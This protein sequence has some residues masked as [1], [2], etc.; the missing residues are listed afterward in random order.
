MH[1]CPNCGGS[2]AD[3]ARFCASCGS[4]L[5]SAPPVCARC[6]TELPAGARFCPSCG[7]PVEDR[8]SPTAERKV[9]TILFADV[10]GST[11]LGERLD[12]EQLRTVL[13]TYFAAMREEIEAEGGTVEKFIGDAVM[14]AFGVPTAHEDDVARALRAAL[15]ML[16]RLASVNE[17]LRADHGVELEIR[18]GVNTGDVLAT[19]EARAGE[20]MVTGDAVNVAARLETA[21]RPGQ[22][23]AA[24]RTVR[25][26]RGFRVEDVGALDLKGKTEPIR[27][28]RV[29]DETVVFPDRGVSGLRAPLVGRDD[30]ID[31]LTS[32]F[33]RV[34]REG[35]PHLVTLYGDAGV[36][37]SRLTREFVESIA[38][39][40]T[41]VRGRCLPYG[42][43]VTFWP[44]A[45][46]LKAQA[47][48]LDT[49]PTEVALE[50]IRKAGRDLL[51]P[52]LTP[53]PAKTTAALAF[54]VGVEDPAFAFGEMDPKDVRAE[55][56]EAWRSF[57][58]A[59][60]VSGPVIALV[61]DI[62]WADPELLALLEDLADRSV[63]P[64]LVLCP[65]RPEL[66]ARHPTWGGGRRNHTAITLDPLSP[67]ESDRLVAY[68]LA[69]DDLPPTVRARILERAEG[70]PFF[71]EEILR[72]L[73]D[74]GLLVHE[75]HRW[76][77]ASG[78]G[79]A[80]IPDTVQGV[81][82]ARIDLLE[83]DDKRVLQAAAVVGRVFWPGSL[84]DLAGAADVAAT[85][86]RLE[87]REL[88]LS[89]LGSSIGGERE[90]L[91]KHIL[92]RDVAYETL[93]KR[94][95]AQAH[96]SVARWIERTAGERAREFV[97][98]LAY[99]YATAVAAR[100][101][102]DE[103]LRRRAVEYLL[104]ASNEA[105]SR[106]VL[107]KA[108][109]L[110]QDALSLTASDAERVRALETLA[111]VFFAA[112]QGDLGWRYFGEAAHLQARLA[113]DTSDPKVAYLCA[114]AAEFPTRWPGS[115]RTLADPAAVEAILDLGA[116]H[117][118]PGDSE[119]RVRLQAIRASWPFAFPGLNP[120]PEEG[121]AYEAAGI[122][123]AEMAIRLGRPDIASGAYDAA[124]GYAI[125][126]GL[127][128]RALDI[129]RRRFELAPALGDAEIADLYAM[130]AW[131]DHDL[132]RYAEGFRDAAEGLGRI[133]GRGARH[134]LHVRAWTCALRFRLGRWDD[135]LNDYR[136]LLDLL[137]ER[138]DDPPYFCSHAFAAAAIVF[139]A[140][141]Q[142]VES[143]RV[144]DLL[145]SLGGAVSSRL[146][147]WLVRLLVE[148]GELDRATAVAERP[149]EAWRV[150]AAVVLE[151]RAELVAAAERWDEAPALLEQTRSYATDSRSR[152]A[153]AVAERL[154]GRASLAADRAD[155]AVRSLTGAC[156]AF[157]EMGS[158]YDEAR[159]AVD[160]ARALTR[161]GRGAEAEARLH[162]AESVFEELRATK[163]LTR[164]RE[165][166]GSPTEE[167]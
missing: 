145:A 124:T 135:A 114:R 76:R 53:D 167:R 61:E 34:E 12:P 123:A 48:V 90:Y 93:P 70:N 88:I 28:F 30:E 38:D 51:T 119:E 120:T 65:S 1:A 43:G 152:S 121:L 137:D 134:E 62:H 20:A 95:R 59:L 155:E 7:T 64:L 132:G 29:L 36:G 47:G 140:R 54:T 157:A 148:R 153:G 136:L 42:E 6:G 129:E 80:D 82:A 60:A 46:I 33:A 63:G 164:I 89:R 23:I 15:R 106:Q 110:G 156:A 162:R 85:L 67:E 108:E 154:A 55:V 27:A 74:A 98:L 84:P 69:I 147:G 158:A 115:M 49:D 92:I 96:A 138:R 161:T 57:F 112:Y 81:L 66:T 142:T 72:Q 166:G 68:L 141:G 32:I 99:H 83:P 118:P 159:T 163:A 116:A 8:P 58:S 87:Q 31:L 143:D 21:A 56:H 10:T 13:E 4:P 102:P 94:Q 9:V 144:T 97:E 101:E 44:L 160:L 45:E 2:N 105:R 78:I 130:V 16:A 150:H 139:D 91:F 100:G 52:E 79:D 50:R 25:A 127:Y 19:P 117:L 125:S 128:E 41:F 17:E 40:A 35:R 149:P 109:R 103:D 146:F 71:L 151:G 133:A 126:L 11:S 86:E 77:A 75:A 73:I 5:V 18:I 122:E 14:A 111:E 131:A 107:A 22:I 165:R 37:K 26:V 24:E 104:S 3:D 39:R 113:A